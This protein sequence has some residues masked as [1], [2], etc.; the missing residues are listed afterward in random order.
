M[1]TCATCG[2]DYDK[3]FTVR[4]HDG[5]SL[6]FDSLECAAHRIAPRCDHCGCVILGHGVEADGAVYCCASCASSRGEHR[7]RDRV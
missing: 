4:T 1:P 5:E 3:A 6:T 7:V 2:N